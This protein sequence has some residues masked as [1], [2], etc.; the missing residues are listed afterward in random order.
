MSLVGQLHRR[1]YGLLLSVHSIAHQHFPVDLPEAVFQV[2]KLQKVYIPA[3]G[4]QARGWAGR[5]TGAVFLPKLSIFCMM[6][7]PGSVDETEE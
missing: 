3:G 2:K 7:M 6:E 4:N 1:S 5:G